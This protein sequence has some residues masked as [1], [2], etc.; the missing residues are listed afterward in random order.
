MR[1]RTQAE[2]D[3]LVADAGFRKLEQRI[4]QWGIF[5]VSLA[6]REKDMRDGHTEGASG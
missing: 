3:Q 5:T 2:M 6:I 1:R 4:D